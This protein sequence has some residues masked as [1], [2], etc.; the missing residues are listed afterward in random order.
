M[1]VDNREMAIDLQADFR[2][3]TTSILKSVF[4]AIP[5]V[6]PAAQELLGIIIP[7]QR[8]DR[9]IT[10]VEL[11]SQ[12]LKELRE[13]FES[14]LSR[15]SDVKYS[16]LFYKACVGSADA[17]S[18]ERIKYIK[19][20]F[21]YG[22]RQTDMQVYKAEALLNLLNRVTDIEIVY[23]R[24]YYL[25]KW[26]LERFKEYQEKTGLFILQPNIY[27]GMT[28]EEIDDEVAKKIYLNN[29]VSYGLLET[30]LDKRGKLKYKCSSVGDLLIRTIDKEEVD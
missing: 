30:K 16:S 21:I 11:L 23:L 9:V 27:S 17:Y 25:L 13:D 14:F 2:D 8:M 7:R 15:I 6:G 1:N 29:L 3:Y 18:E 28:H 12:D 22:L 19:N 20:I 24:M 4:G 26:N 10:F 5:I